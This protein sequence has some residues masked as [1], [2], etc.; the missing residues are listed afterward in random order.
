MRVVQIVWIVGFLIGTSSHITDLVQYGT[1]AYA[2]HPIVVRLFWTSLTIIDPL[3]A[4]LLV[5]RQRAGIILAIVVILADIVV[6]WTVF[7]VVDGTPL[8]GAV[9]QTVLAAFIV[10]T[11]RMMWHWFPGGRRS[12]RSTD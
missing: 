4:L 8:F 11:A 9:D 2:E 5:L 7:A 6:N 10:V 1:Q 12:H 3:T